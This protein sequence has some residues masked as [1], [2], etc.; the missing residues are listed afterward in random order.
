MQ[1]Y[2]PS[3][4]GEIIQEYNKVLVLVVQ[5]GWEGLDVHMDKL[6][7]MFST[8]RGWREG[9]LRLFAFSATQTDGRVLWDCKIGKSR[10]MLLGLPD[11]LF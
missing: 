7:G 9:S 5:V 10:G 2:G 8:H 3:H 1:W 4:G 11:N 6:K